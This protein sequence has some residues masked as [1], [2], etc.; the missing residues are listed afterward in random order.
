MIS[1]SDLIKLP[2]TPDLTRAGI[3]YACRSLPYTFDRMGGSSFDRMRRI[4]AGV[5]V[6][7]AFR[8]LLTERGV[9]YDTQGTTPFTD[10]DHYDICLGGRRCDIKSFLIFKK[11]EIRKIRKDP[12]YLI[13]ATAL[14]P[15]DQLEAGRMQ[16]SD[17]YIFAF[18]TALIT[19]RREEMEKALAAGQPVYII[20][21]LPGSWAQPKRWVS[22]GKLAL[23]SEASAPF[24]LEIGG[25]GQDRRFQHEQIAVSPLTRI[26]PKSIFYTLAYL[27]ASHRPDGRLAL[28]S[29]RSRQAYTITP[30]DWDNIW[31]YGMEIFMA[32]YMTCGE[33]RRLAH[34]LPAGNRVLQYART[35]TANMALPLGELRPLDDLLNRVRDW[36]KRSTLRETN[37]RISTADEH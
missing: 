13:D 25:Q 15:L 17:L 21:P 5:A 37:K 26:E 24:S 27:H 31:V 12:G 4:A 36:S 9:P 16:A 14:V 8:R 20:H 23:K 11:D 22:L 18:V 33:Y 7:I 6:E 1:S 34:R 3:D 28:R 35:R 2:Y 32:G 19:R 29:S 30:D 10:P